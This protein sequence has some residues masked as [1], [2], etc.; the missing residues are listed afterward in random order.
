MN[1][2]E[3][4]V[5]GIKVSRVRIDSPAEKAGIKNGDVIVELAGRR[6]TH[7]YH[8]TYAVDSL[9]IGKGTTIV[10]NR[11]RE[12]MSFRILPIGKK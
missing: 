6:I 2:I 10:V 9:E 11:G 12:Q 3:N 5:V 1:Y 4:D 7:V 8:Y